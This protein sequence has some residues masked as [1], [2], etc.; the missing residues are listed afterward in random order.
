MAGLNRILV[1]DDEASIRESLEMFLRE[2]GLNV[3]TAGTAEAG[4]GKWRRLGPQVIILDIRLPDRSGLD[5]LAEITA[6]DREVKVI[7]ITAHHDMETTIAA[8][9]R[10]AY[11]YIH[12]PLDVEE[13]GKGPGQG[14]AHRPHHP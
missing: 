12:K 7:M 13:L 8:M 3:Q 9:R 10:G 11:D 6:K 1:I 5:V 4:M 14:A 2:K